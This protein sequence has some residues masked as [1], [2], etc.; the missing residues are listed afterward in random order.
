M[1]CCQGDLRVHDGGTGEKTLHTA[2]LSLINL[3]AEYCA[4]AWCHRVHTHLIDS[5]NDGLCIVTGCLCSTPTNNFSVLSGI[6]PAELCCQGVTLSQANHNSLDPGHI[7]H[8]QLTEL[9][10]ASKERLK[11]RHL[12]VSAAW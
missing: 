4:P 9:K 1:F 8:G 12:L 3:T 11:S 2:T 5:I 10:A 7:L 6:Q